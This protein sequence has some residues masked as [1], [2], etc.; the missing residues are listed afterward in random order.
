MD[1]HPSGQV[2]GVETCQKLCAGADSL[3]GRI[4]SPA[5]LADKNVN[6]R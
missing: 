3:I 6:I 5:G 1:A 4:C 2:C